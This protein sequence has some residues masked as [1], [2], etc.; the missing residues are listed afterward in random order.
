MFEDMQGVKTMREVEQGK[1]QDKQFVLETSQPVLLT[2]LSNLSGKESQKGQYKLGEDVA[3]TR[4]QSSE[5]ETTSSFGDDDVDDQ[6]Q[7]VRCPTSPKLKTAKSLMRDTG[8]DIEFRVDGRIETISVVRKPLGLIFDK[9]SSPVRISTVREGSHAAELGVQPGWEVSRIANTDVR[10]LGVEEVQAEMHAHVASLFDSA[11]FVEI[12]FIADDEEKTLIF[13]RRRRI[14]FTLAQTEPL[15]I[16]DVKADSHAEALGVQA[17]W[18]VKAVAGK[19]L[20]EMEYWRAV[21]EFE[22]SVKPASKA[23]NFTS[24]MKRARAGASDEQSG[25]F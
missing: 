19:D 18:I 13:Q 6:G 8:F 10:T 23:E 24:F 15:T 3:S 20:L 17:G 12:V 22:F 25:A 1:F 7:P 21:D 9:S 4:T 16:A 11:E 2:S 14:G 5:T